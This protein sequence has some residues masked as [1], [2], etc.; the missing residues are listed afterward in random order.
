MKWYR[1]VSQSFATHTLTKTWSS[2]IHKPLMVLFSNTWVCYSPGNLCSHCYSLL[3]IHSWDV[4]NVHNPKATIQV[5][6]N[7]SH[8]DL[9][10]ASQIYV[11]VPSWYLHEGSRPTRKLFFANYHSSSSQLRLVKQSC[12]PLAT[13]SY[14][15]YNTRS[16]SML[17]WS[18]CTCTA[19]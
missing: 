18:I 8:P 10:V 13:Y 3:G 19:E 14:P 17:Q 6:H 4:Y 7:A 16:S 15:V 12:I 11:H 2:Y 1:R 9:R 5:V